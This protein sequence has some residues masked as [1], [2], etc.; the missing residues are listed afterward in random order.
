MQCQSKPKVKLRFMNIPDEQ[1]DPEVSGE[2]VRIPSLLLPLQRLKRMFQNL[3]IHIVVV[4]SPLSTHLQA[5]DRLGIGLQSI[6]RL[7]IGFSHRPSLV[8]LDESR[9][10]CHCAGAAI[11]SSQIR[12]RNSLSRMRTLVVRSIYKKW[13]K[14]V[15]SRVVCVRRY[16]R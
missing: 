3:W 9:F 15:R 4:N 16:C 1:N 2:Q 11:L 12:I 13:L 5:A 8:R 7:A 14:L 6:A 10:G